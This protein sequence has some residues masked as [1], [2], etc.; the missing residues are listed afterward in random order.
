MIM[1]T[2]PI[3]AFTPINV[4][5]QPEAYPQRVPVTIRPQR[6]QV[7]T[8]VPMNYLMGSCSD[9][10]DNP[11]NPV[12]PDLDDI[13]KIEKAMVDLP[14]QLKDR[15]RWLEEKFKAIEN[16]D[17]HCRV[18]AKDLSLVPDLVLPPK[19]KTLEF[20]KYNG[21]SCPEAHIMIHVTD[22]TPD[23]ITLQNME[24]KLS[25]SFWQYA[26]RWRE[27]VT[28]VQPPL[29][30]K[31][32]TMLFINTLKALF[33]KHMLGSA[34]KSFSNIV[35]SGEMIENVIRGKCDNREWREENQDGCAEVKTPLRW[36]WKKMV[37]GGLITQDLGE[38][39]REARDYCE[40]HDKEGH[41]IQKCVEFRA[42]IQGLMD[43]KE[44]EFFE[45]TKLPEGKDNYDCNMT[46]LREENPVST[47][48]EGQNVG[49]P[50][51]KAEPV[52][53]KSLVV[54]QKK[55]KPARLESPVNEPIIEKKAKEF[56]KFLKHSKYSVVEQLHK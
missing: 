13:A 38:R 23:R 16:V 36:V 29:L 46:I 22:M 41:E 33:I 37:E 53:G 52:E 6:Y 1:K 2:L 44:L 17:Y 5:I 56:L 19:F 55:E 27:V 11:T 24:K 30:E 9:P 4:Q 25:E 51:T 48:E 15:C 45:Y 3:D 28:Q 7:G 21:A 18:D 34:T 32:T 54:E 31:E 50:N 20:E 39:P 26:Q 35:M 43:N 10:G 14:K 47:S 12:V 8:S 49:F 42:L 40:Y